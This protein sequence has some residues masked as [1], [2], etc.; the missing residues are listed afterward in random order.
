MRKQRKLEICEWENTIFP[1]PVK[2]AEKECR[3]S[4]SGIW[5]E[6]ERGLIAL[7]YEA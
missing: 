4:E 6:R 1:F 2:L 5:A 3:G 7:I